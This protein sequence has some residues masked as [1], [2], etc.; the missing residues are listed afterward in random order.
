MPGDQPEAK[1]QRVADI[2]VLQPEEEFLA[3]YSGGCCFGGVWAPLATHL[4][5]PL[6]T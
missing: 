4:G 1:R 2:F 6:G 5:R 3:K